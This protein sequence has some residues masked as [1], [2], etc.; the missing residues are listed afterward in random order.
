MNFVEPWLENIDSGHI[1]L[2]LF[3]F[4][5][6]NG[7]FSTPPSEVT[8]GLAGFVASHGR[9]SALGL[10]AAGV[11]GNVLGTTLLYLLASRWGESAVRRI[12]RFNPLLGDSLLAATRLAFER[13]GTSIVLVGRCLPVVRSIVSIPAGLSHM[14]LKPFLLLTTAGCLLWA[15]LWGGAGLLIG[16]QVQVLI[17]ETKGYSLGLTLLLLALVA[18]W[19]KRQTRVYLSVARKG[20]IAPPEGGTPVGQTGPGR[21]S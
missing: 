18:L 2:V 12:M 21:D 13:H 14:R 15:L 3:L 6:F 20:D 4:M 16:Q 9:A 10:L 7:F 1:Y 19:L 17:Q 8:W 11:G 5:T